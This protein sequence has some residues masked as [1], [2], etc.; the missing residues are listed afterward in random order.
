[1]STTTRGWLSL[2]WNELDDKAVDTVRVVAMDAVQSVSGAQ[3]PP[4]GAK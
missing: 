4:I 3:S 2:D 1:M